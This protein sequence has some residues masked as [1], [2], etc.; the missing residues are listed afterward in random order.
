[1]IPRDFLEKDENEDEERVS[2]AVSINPLAMWLWIAGPIFLL[3]T[4]IALWPHPSL[5]RASENVELV[6]ERHV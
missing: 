1:M 4:A 2:L 6:S 3:G 5:E